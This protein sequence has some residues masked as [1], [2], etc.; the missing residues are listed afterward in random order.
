MLLCYE[1]CTHIHTLLI[2]FVYFSTL[3]KCH[4]GAIFLIQYNKDS[5]IRQISPFIWEKGESEYH[6]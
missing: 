6:S 2:T 5:C 1:L 3:K 4:F